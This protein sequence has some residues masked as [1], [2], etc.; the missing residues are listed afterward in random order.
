GK[1]N[2]FKS[3]FIVTISISAAAGEAAHPPEK[4]LNPEAKPSAIALMKL[5]GPGTKEYDFGCETMLLLVITSSKT[6][7]RILCGSLGFSGASSTN[8]SSISS[9]EPETTG[10][11]WFWVAKCSTMASTTL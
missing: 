6:N 9:R 4:I 2:I 10:N 3:Q 5:L 8:K 11:F 1:P 7:F